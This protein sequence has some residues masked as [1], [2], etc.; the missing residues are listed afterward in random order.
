LHGVQYGQIQATA[1]ENRAP[2]KP[3]GDMR[4]GVRIDSLEAAGYVHF[5]PA[6]EEARGEFHCA[7][8]GYGVSVQRR[9]PLCPMCGG[10]AWEQAGPSTPRLQ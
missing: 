8:C 3:R 6:G 10:T 5:V 9:L 2:L 7:D 4:D 1:R